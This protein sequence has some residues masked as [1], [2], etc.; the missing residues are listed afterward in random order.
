MAFLS[1]SR[2]LF[3][4][5][6]YQTQTYSRLT[7][8]VNLRGLTGSVNMKPGE[9]QDCLDV[10]PREDGAIYRVYGWERVNDTALSGRPIGVWGF[11]YRGKNVPSGDTARAGNFSQANTDS[12]FTKR[13][14]EFSGYILLTTT[15][16]Y[17]W[18]P[19]TSAF[20]T[21]SLPAG[22]SVDIVKPSFA[23]VND[24]IYI[25]GWADK[26]LRYD[27]TDHALYR[28]GW[29]A[30]PGVPAL[31]AS[32]SSGDLIVG[33]KYKYGYSFF[34]IYTAEESFMSES[35]EI[36]IAEPNRTVTVT[37][38]AYTG[39]RH[40]NDLATSSDSDVGVIIWR[41]LAD[42]EEYYFITTLNPGVLTYDD[43]DALGYV[44][45]LLPARGTQQ[46]E[47]R[48][49]SFHEFRGRFYA[50]SRFD[51]SNRL[52]FSDNSFYERFRVRS[53]VDL[54]V[55]EGDALTAVGATDTTILAHTRRGGFRVTANET[56]ASRPQI[57]QTKLP[58]EAGAVGPRAR[59][60]RNG[61]EYW[62]SERGPMRW[63]EGM[64]APQW[65]GKPLAPMFVDPTSGLCK[66]NAEAR[67][68][69]EIGFDWETNTMRFLFATG[70]SD[71][72]DQ[73]WAYWIDA[74]KYNGDPESGWFPLS[75]RAQAMTRSHSITSVTIDGIPISA[76]DRIERMTFAD[77]DGYV[78]Q[79]ETSSR[80]GGLK[81]GTLSKGLV[82]SS[83]TTT[84]VEVDGGL[85]TTGDGLKGLRCEIV[86]ADGTRHARTI[87]SN[88]DTAITLETALPTAPAADDVF[89][90]GGMPAFWRSWVDHMGDPHSKKTV[91]HL[92][93]GMQR[94]ASA[95][96]QSGELSDW[97]ADISVGRGEFPQTFK[98]SRPVTLDLYRRKMLVS[99]TGVD[100]VYEIGNT[101]PDEGF[102][103][104]NLAPD[105][106]IVPEKGRAQ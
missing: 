25:V 19:S 14:N 52:F 2:P 40:F 8:G 21:V 7:L 81:P 47:P 102:V 60:T 64:L 45:D 50:T 54:P 67:E 33:A 93:V 4:V 46:D 92:Y 30:V 24:S 6:A 20:V 17:R 28:W 10:M 87:A 84:V 82:A 94:M 22:A 29:E 5:M 88:T 72:P 73:N 44:A 103:V 104:T 41:T 37:T 61:Y 57:I 16:F 75:P 65:I 96:V 106:E 90:V 27:P 55:T 13:N 98:L 89:Y 97:R 79:Y 74:E 85:F 99:A 56:G 32:L 71:F 91:L 31:A 100:W 34:N 49:T 42:Q 101:R 62:L 105:V 48:F 43:G 77:D 35:A 76:L 12:D 51:N 36:T 18:N 26:N 39:A 70:T 9:A 68:L 15:T 58:W 11:D 78:Y 23:V 1:R 86:Y 59:E 69:S 3:Q 83:S 63:A 53:F 95:A 66:L 80:R 38:V